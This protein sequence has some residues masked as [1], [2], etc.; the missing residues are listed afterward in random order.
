MNKLSTKQ[1]WMVGLM[2]FSLFFG[3]GNLIFPPMVGKMSGTSMYSSMLFFSITAVVLPVLGVIA[4]AKS[5]GLINMGKKVSPWFATLFTI[6]IYLSM[7]PL[8]GIP[9]AGT[10]PFEIGIAPNL[11]EG[12]A[13]RSALFVFTLLFFSTTYWLCLNPM[14]MA[15][16]VGKYL[17]P[18]LLVMMV[19]L[20]ICSLINPMGSPIQPQAEYASNPYISGFIEG[21]M[22]MDAMGALNF[23][24]VIAMVIHSFHI[25]EERAVIHS[26]IKTG[27]LAGALLFGI[28][29]M[30]AH[31]GATSINLYPQTTNGAQI[32]NAA[33]NHLFGSFGAI[34]VAGIFM[35]ACLTTCIGL[36]TSSAQY[37]A[38]WT[39]KFSYKGWV[40]IWI[41]CSLLLANVG[42][43]AILNYSGPI[44]TALY[45]VAIV[46]ILLVIADSLFNGE[47]AVYKITVYTTG[48]VSILNGLSELGIQIPLITKAIEKLPLYSLQLS[49]V[50][51][52]IVAFTVGCIY[53]KA[54]K[55]RLITSVVKDKS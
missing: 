32:L 45:P 13:S 14:K 20:F 49:W 24:L 41:V 5:K 51:P 21:Y 1:F 46:M 22:T 8:M 4:V 40:R 54:K 34:L 50:I 48:I 12:F 52:A 18:I 17:S 55:T 47:Q 31:L 37:F 9:R 39:K 15:E 23:G 35:L 36:T 27:V 33:S 42:L 38:T 19:L 44:L 7:G 30:L 25:K 11:P 2:L 10:V 3:A 43:D 28:Y 53:I 26:T 29:M 16:R 6:I